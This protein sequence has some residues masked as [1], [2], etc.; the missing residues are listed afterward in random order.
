MHLCF[1]IILI[2]VGNE[3]IIL[4]VIHIVIVSMLP[5]EMLL[6][7]KYKVSNPPPFPVHDNG[8]NQHY[9]NTEFSN[10][11][12]DNYPWFTTYCNLSLACQY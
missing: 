3:G 1:I 5:G 10:Y 6:Y 11:N 9:A 4:K 7:H 8:Y 2:A 12:L